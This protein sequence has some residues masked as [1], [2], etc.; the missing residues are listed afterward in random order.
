MQ[1]QTFRTAII[2]AGI[3][4]GVAATSAAAQAELDTDSDGVLS[5]DELLAGYPDMSEATFLTMDADAS[6]TIDRSELAAAMD[7]GTL[8]AS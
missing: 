4:L 2:A 3:A 1:I 8:P 7:A 5:Y 6:G